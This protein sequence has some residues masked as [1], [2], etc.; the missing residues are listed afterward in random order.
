MQRVVQAGGEALLLREAET[1]LVARRHHE[2]VRAALE[3]LWRLLGAAPPPAL[4]PPIAASATSSLS[5]SSLSSS[6]LSSSSLVS[7]SLPSSCLPHLCASARCP[8]APLLSVLAQALFETRRGAEFLPFVLR[9]FGPL[10][11]PPP[12]SVLELAARLERAQGRS[13]AAADLL[14]AVLENNSNNSNNNNSNHTLGEHEKT[15]LRQ[16]LAL[17]QQPAPKMREET[18]IVT[19]STAASAT[20]AVKA[21]PAPA[22]PAPAAP[23]AASN[24]SSSIGDK[25]YFPYGRKGVLALAGVVGLFGIWRARVVL[26]KWAREAFVLAFG[27]S[28]QVYVP[29]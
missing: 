6:S 16:L 3:A 8:C 5:S 21:L 4:S 26:G 2:A 23:S 20:S 19:T 14:A 24:S 12:L 15:R 22:L 18:K 13:D 10:S 9:L 29:R 17:C 1:L 7:L 27:G 25:F 11:P 28:K